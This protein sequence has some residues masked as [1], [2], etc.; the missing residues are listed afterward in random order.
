MNQSKNNV[1]KYCK[2]LRSPSTNKLAIISDMLSE[3]S[4][5]ELIAMAKRA[6]KMYSSLVKVK[7]LKRQ[8]YNKVASSGYYFGKEKDICGYFGTLAFIFEQNKEE[9]NLFVD[10]FYQ[11]EKS[12]LLGEYEKSLSIIHEINNSVSYSLWG[13]DK[14][15]KLAR[16]TKGL[17]GAT[18]IYNKLFSENKKLSFSC[19]L[20]FKTS[21]IDVPFDSDV[22]NILK[23]MPDQYTKEFYIIHNFPYIDINEGKW[24]Y[25]NSWFSIVDLYCG[26]IYSLDNLSKETIQNKSFLRYLSIISDTINDIRL[27]KRCCLINIQNNSIENEIDRKDII[28]NYF[29][30]RYSLV[31]SKGEKYIFEKPYDISII[32]LY[33]KSCIIQQKKIYEASNNS[34][35]IQKIIYFYYSYLL[36]NDN[37]DVFRKKLLNLC[38]VWYSMPSIKHLYWIIKDRSSNDITQLSKNFWRSSYGINIQDVS[39]FESD[40]SKKAFVSTWDG[41]FV[42]LFNL[43]QQNHLLADRVDFYDLQL[44]GNKKSDVVSIL[45]ELDKS[46]E[47][48]TIPTFS[49]NSICTYVFN[50]YFAIGLIKEAIELFAREMTAKE[51]LDLTLIDEKL[52]ND[53]L[54]SDTD[55]QFP[56]PLDFSIFYT[57]VNA[58]PYKRYLALKRFLEQKD[59]NKVSELKVDGSEKLRFFLENVAD[60]Q[61]LALHRVFRNSNEVIDERILIYKNLF[62]YYKDKRYLEEASS[63]SK[64]QTISGL[65]QRVDDSKIYVDI[66]NIKNKELKD[67]EFNVLFDVFRNTDDK[68]K[69]LENK[70]P[71][72]LQILSL[73]QSEGLS[74]TLYSTNESMEIDYKLSLFRK[75]YLDVRDKF[76]FDPKYGLDYYLST[77]IRHG[78]IDNQLRNHLQEYHLVTNTDDSGKYIDNLYWLKCFGN[79]RKCKD[80]L[81]EFSQSADNLIYALKN[82]RIQIKTEDN[83]SKPKAVFDFSSDKLS[84][85]LDSLQIE[86]AQTDFDN[87]V[88]LIFNKLWSYTEICLIQMREVLDETHNLLRK[89]LDQLYSDIS[90]TLQNNNPYLNDFKDSIT[91][92]Q[93]QLQS[94]F[95]KVQGWFQ[96]KDVSTFDFSIQQV[97]DASLFAINRI[98][99]G[100]LIVQ[101]N[102]NST[103]SFKGEYFGVMHDLFHDIL[104]NVLDYEKKKRSIKGKAI[105]NIDENN[106]MLNVMVTN[107]VAQE[108]VQGLQNII[109]ES[110]GRYSSLISKGRSRLEGKSGFAKIYNIVTNVFESKDNRY[111]NSVKDGLFKVE[112]SINV[113][114][115][116]RK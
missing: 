8:S 79:S 49:R 52:I 18:S 77:R 115:L 91:S 59:V 1:S 92:C 16:L 81:N 5:D 32:D 62:D 90:A 68:V 95:S 74:L 98:N 4:Y 64:E 43:L 57:Y 114:N 93:T 72:I 25:T 111:H 69:V 56:N 27:K 22:E 26:F 47:D 41:E 89:L 66:E 85:Y 34:P 70:S 113:T 61:V 13:A 65:V 112:I 35:I 110:E 75:L 87:C 51:H 103:S 104:N 60:R 11:F 15:I 39:F 33:V 9:L 63:L 29:K 24:I 30:K 6:S 100:A 116:I 14:E 107:P 31:I 42:K 19:N 88:S 80:I 55:E 3:L 94:D 37:S 78:T 105:V 10:L 73:L 109:L 20:S 44:F 46:I 50:H 28:L 53:F 102:I 76:V 23:R 40:E 106:Q 108:D 7:Y 36:N 99:Q 2:L 86:C 58:A 48:K 97:I 54:D 45:K 101:M 84:Q 21:A 71:E 83:N 38:E 96:L 12:I 17:T 82:E 67:K